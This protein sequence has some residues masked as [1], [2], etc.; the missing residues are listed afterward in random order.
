[1]DVMELLSSNL[2]YNNSLHQQS[3]SSVSGSSAASITMSTGQRVGKCDCVLL[4]TFSWGRIKSAALV[5]QTFLSLGLS[6]VS[7]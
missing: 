1:M 5:Q 7:V 3:Q 6:T 2:C 4:T